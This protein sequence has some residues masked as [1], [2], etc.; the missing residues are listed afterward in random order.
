LEHLEALMS[1]AKGLKVLYVEDDVALQKETK[2]IL[3]RI[4]QNVDAA[5]DGQEGLMA[6]K[7]NRYDL[8]L[9][10]IEMPNL[11]GLKMSEEIKSINSSIPIIII[12]AYSNTEYL[13]D[14]ISIGIDNYILKPI[15]MPRFIDTLYS[16]V[17]HIHNSKIAEEYHKKEVQ[18]KVLESSE[19][20]MRQISQASPNAIVVY[21]DSKLFFASEAFC[22]LFD[23]M[24]IKQLKEQVNE[25]SNFLNQKIS[26]DQIFEECESFVR[27]V[28]EEMLLK[29]DVLKISLQSQKGKK[30]F[31]LYVSLLELDNSS[32]S[33]MFT[34]NDITLLEFQRKQ[35][36]Q[37]SEYMG[38]LTA[39]KYKTQKDENNPEIIDK[40]H[41]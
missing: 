31:Y 22:A 25:F 36:N 20:V 32:K 18:L 39:T 13:I 37:Y 21:K 24:E 16:V 34:F 2:K 12:S 5:S 11:D 30:V 6:F 8:I 15:K 7:E 40:L 26:I 29:S 33:I 9:S 3:D 35:I 1:L 27:K 4:F 17:K 19:N 28:D 41:F 14:A 10:D 38:D 23:A